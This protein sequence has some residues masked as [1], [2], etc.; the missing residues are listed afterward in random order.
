MQKQ[1]NAHGADPTVQTDGDFG[2]KT[3]NAVGDFQAANGLAQDKVC[4]PLTWAKLD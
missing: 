3:G 1:L 4:G 2:S